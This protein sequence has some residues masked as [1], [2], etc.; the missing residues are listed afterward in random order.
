[1]NWMTHPTLRIDDA[2]QCVSV[3]PDAVQLRLIVQHLDVRRRVSHFQEAVFEW[4]SSTFRFPAQQGRNG[5]QAGKCPNGDDHD[6]H[7]SRSPLVQVCHW[8]CDRP[9][10]IQTNDAQIQNRGRAQKHVQSSVNFTPGMKK[11]EY[12]QNRPQN[13][14][15]LSHTRALRTSSRPSVRKPM[16]MAWWGGRSA[17]LPRPAKQ[18]TNSERWKFYWNIFT[19]FL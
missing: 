18:W 6:K 10:S 14:I 7:F 8:I 19:D 4:A 3:V 2:L 17:Y 15:K 11:V 12:F 9:I 5:D 16:R 1:M 13:C